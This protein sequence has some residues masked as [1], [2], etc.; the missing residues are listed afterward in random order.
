M[1]KDIWITGVV[2]VM[3]VVLLACEFDEKAADDEY[4]T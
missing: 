1:F 4:G 2:S 3:A